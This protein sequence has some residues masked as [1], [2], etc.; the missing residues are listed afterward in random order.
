MTGYNTSRFA[1]LMSVAA[2]TAV[3]ALPAAAE[4]APDLSAAVIKT[5]PIEQTVVI[6]KSDLSTMALASKR[7]HDNASRVPAHGR[8]RQRQ[9]A[10]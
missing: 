5:P 1:N 2:M 10:R 6:P 8:R 4:V 3:L 7:L 9:S